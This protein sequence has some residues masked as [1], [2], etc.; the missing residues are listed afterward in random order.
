MSGVDLLG[1]DFDAPAEQPVVI[2]TQESPT[3]FFPSP[4]PCSAGPVQNDSGASKRKAAVEEAIVVYPTVA[5]AVADKAADLKQTKPHDSAALATGAVTQAGGTPAPRRYMV[6]CEG[7]WRVRSDPSM[8]SKVLGT[9]AN[10]TIVVG[11]DA[12]DAEAG[13][14]AFVPP[15]ARAAPLRLSSGSGVEG[16]H[17]ISSLWVVVEQF[18][19]QAPMGVSEIKRDTAS[20]GAMYCL[21]RNALGYGLYEIGVEP[22]EGSLVTLPEELNSELRSD[23]QQAAADRSEDVSFTWKLLGAAESFTRFMSQQMSAEGGANLDVKGPVKRRPEEAF[24]AKQR[25]QLKKA[26][27]NLR[28]VVLKI[29]SKVQPHEDATAGLPKETRRRFARL[30]SSLIAASSACR[31]LV[32]LPTTGENSSPSN[33]SGSVIAAAAA[34]PPAPARHSGGYPAALDQ[35]PQS[36]LPGDAADLNQFV[37][38]CSRMERP[39][40]WPELNTEVKQEVIRFSCEFCRELEDYARVLGKDAANISGSSPASA[41]PTANTSA[42]P[43]STAAHSSLFVGDLMPLSSRTQDT[44]VDDTAKANAFVVLSPTASHTP[45]PLPAAALLGDDVPAGSNV[46]A[47]P[48][49]GFACGS[50]AT[51][52]PPASSAAAPKQAPGRF[53]P[54]LPPPPPPSNAVRQL[55]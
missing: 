21:R 4:A 30:R 6:R 22:M 55:I 37:D 31:P 49:A 24:E 50:V 36:H 18:E 53:V 17:T 28:K 38:F 32:V 1:L 12:H 19:A 14:A 20:G 25:E 47:S 41:L 5:T 46:Q 11:N 39:G 26:S 44:V 54:L 16:G 3:I 7:R 33:S 40:G 10:G 42:E 8:N 23:A 13:A 51:V 15:A 2:S 9:I 35:A 52:A 29:V 43:S 48:L 34:P 27:V 45:S